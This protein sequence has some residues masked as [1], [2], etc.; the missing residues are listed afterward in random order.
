MSADD[1]RGPALEFR[2]VHGVDEKTA[3]LLS[4]GN[5]TAAYP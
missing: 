2:D 1:L 5:G 3:Y 4:A